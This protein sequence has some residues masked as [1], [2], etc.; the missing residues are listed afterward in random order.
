MV[1]GIASVIRRS[2]RSS[3]RSFSSVRFRFS[4]SV[5]V[6]YHLEY[7]WFL[8]RSEPLR[9]DRGAVVLV[10]SSSSTSGGMTIRAS[11]LTRHTAGDGRSARLHHASVGIAS[12]IT[13]NLSSD[14]FISGRLLKFPISCFDRIMLVRVDF[15]EHPNSRAAASGVSS[16]KTAHDVM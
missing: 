5:F 8:F 14:I 4:I 10:R 2:S 6:P 9:D 1:R 13:R 11:L 15:S 3:C 7:H 16:Q 12:T